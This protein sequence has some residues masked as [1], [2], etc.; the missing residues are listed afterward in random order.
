MGNEPVPSART[1][2]RSSESPIDTARSLTTM[3]SVRGLVPALA[4]RSFEIGTIAAAFFAESFVSAN[5]IPVI[6]IS[7]SVPI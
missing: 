5:V 7:V 3:S 6:G 1:K 2:C 4:I